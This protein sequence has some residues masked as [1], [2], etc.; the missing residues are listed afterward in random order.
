MTKRE[1][2]DGVAPSGQAVNLEIW[3]KL[4]TDGNFMMYPSETLVRIIRQRQ[5]ENCLSGVVLDHGAGSGNIAEFLVRIGCQVHCTD[6]SAKA[7]ETIRARFAANRLPAPATTWIDIGAPLGPQLPSYDH[8]ITWQSA[9]YN[10]LANTR[11]S[12]KLLIDKLPRG[13]TFISCFPSINDL[14]AKHSVLLP[15]GSR[16]LTGGEQDGAIITIPASTEE[17][18]FWCNGLDIRDVITYGTC[19]RTMRTEFIVVF[20]VKE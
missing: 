12:L 3:D 10:T 13:G 18:V 8:V 20:G 7:I 16:R 14:Q 6:V 5:A 17:M 9:Y 1:I 4:Y 15:D 19:G 11:A 2:T